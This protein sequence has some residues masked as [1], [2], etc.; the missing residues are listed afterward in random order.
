MN[1]SYDNQRYLRQA[2]KETSNVLAE[3]VHSTH[4]A[5][6]LIDTLSLIAGMTIL[7]PEEVIERYSE[8]EEG[9]HDEMHRPLR[10]YIEE[11][12]HPRSMQIEDK[13]D[14]RTFDVSAWI[15]VVVNPQ[16]TR[17]MTQNH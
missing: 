9:S 8:S 1:E 15:K 14:P 4:S 5:A 10:N 12:C 13:I 17:T 7:S 3:V 16:N 2:V 11:V 6:R